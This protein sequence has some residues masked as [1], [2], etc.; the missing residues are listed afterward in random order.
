MARSQFD[1]PLVYLFGTTEENENKPSVGL[2]G[3]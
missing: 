3:I 1:K 2:S